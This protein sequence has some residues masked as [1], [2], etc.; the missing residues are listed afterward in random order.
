MSKYRFDDAYGAVYKYSEE[1]KAYVYL[2]SFLTAGIEPSDSEARQIREA[3]YVDARFSYENDMAL[4]PRADT[5]AE[6]VFKAAS[7]AYVKAYEAR[8]VAADICEAA[9]AAYEA[10]A[11]AHASACPSRAA[12]AYN[13]TDKDSL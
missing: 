10:E 5:T 11:D 7:D 1:C 2:C 13:A 8:R 12:A 4:P 6:A 3:E 9:H